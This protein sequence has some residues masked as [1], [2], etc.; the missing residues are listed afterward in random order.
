MCVSSID[1]TYSVYTIFKIVTF[2][3]LLITLFTYSV[4]QS[5]LLSTLFNPCKNYIKEGTVL[6]VT[7]SKC[8][9]FEFCLHLTLYYISVCMMKGNIFYFIYSL[10]FFFFA[11]RRCVPVPFRCAIVRVAHPGYCTMLAKTLNCCILFLWS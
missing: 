2:N 1:V 7:M 9:K 4:D 3:L 6:H 10:E 8:L 11:F 5:T